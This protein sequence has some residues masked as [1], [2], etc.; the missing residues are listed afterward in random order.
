MANLSLTVDGLKLPNPLVIASG[1]P[2]TNANVISKA[3]DEGW[4][5]VICKT[6]SLDSSKVTNVQ[7]RYARLRTAESKEIIGWENIELI[8]DRP[9]DIWLDEF[10]QIKD[11]HPDGVLIASIMEE[12]RQEAWVE[13]VE[14]CQ[15]AGV[16]GFECNF[17]CPHGLPERRMGSAMGEDPEILEEV[18]RW[19]MSA[20][21]VPVWA[22]MTPNVT[23]V[24]SPSRAAL[25][26][27]CN[28]IS[29]I[30][31][32]RS[33]IG[34]NLETLR[35]EPSVEGYTTLGGYSCKAV[36]PIALR[37]CMEIARLIQDEFP[38]RSLSGMGGVESGDD[39]A[40]FILLGCDT[41]QV[42]THVMK[43]GYRCVR[44]MLDQLSAFMDRHKFE[45]LSD[46]KG[47]SL[48][49]FTT[50]FDLVQRQAAARQAARKVAETVVPNGQPIKADNEWRGDEFVKQT[51]ALARG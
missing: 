35:P 44:E 39:A 46:F 28:G 42:C 48:Q 38:G 36:M 12:Y 11:R 15:E 23:R 31:T 29:A 5:A 32:I 34:V 41:V 20:A 19:V 18:C 37:I 9:F 45:T 49:F 43:V 26:A 27:G 40:Q 51:D 17:S 2:G 24:E 7:P 50:H 1:P 6:V 33:V 14:R 3:F 8:S 16:D 13:I 22:K 4:G 10:K 47:H 25:A 21:K 30:N